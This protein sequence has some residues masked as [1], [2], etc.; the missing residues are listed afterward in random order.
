MY[1]EKICGFCIRGNFRISNWSVVE[2][3][4]TKLRLMGQPN[5]VFRP[6]NQ[7]RPALGVK[8]YDYVC[9][10]GIII[11]CGTVAPYITYRCIRAKTRRPVSTKRKINYCRFNI[12]NFPPSRIFNNYRRPSSRTCTPPQLSWPF[13]IGAGL[14]QKG[15][16]NEATMSSYYFHVAFW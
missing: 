8:V 13:T 14:Y 7:E 15:P 1:T 6:S 11:S 9:R 5:S 2:G 10:S 3:T 12:H 4:L 16:F